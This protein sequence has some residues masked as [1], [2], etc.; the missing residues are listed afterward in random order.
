MKILFIIL[1]I[2]LASVYFYMKQPALINPIVEPQLNSDHYSNGYFNNPIESPVSTSSESFVS[3]LYKFVFAKYE[4]ATPTQSIPSRKTNLHQL[5]PSENIIVWMGHSSYYMQL[6]GKKFLIDPVFSENA[7][8]VPMTNLAFAGSNIYRAEDIPEIDYLLITHDHWDHL[9]YPTLNALRAKIDQIITPIGVGSYLV[10]WGFDANKIYQGDWFTTFE[11]QDVTI[12]VLPA[13]HFSG[14]MLERNQ[15]LW[16]SF[17]IVTAK[18]TIYFSGD[19]GYSPHFKQ[20]AEQIGDID[21]AVLENGQYNDDWAYIHMTPEQAVQAAKDLG[22]KAVL[23][24]HNS[25]F[26]LSRHTW[27]D[28]LQRVY[29]ASLNQPFKLMTPMIGEMVEIDNDQQAFS[30]WWQEIK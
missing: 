3:K 28:P 17:A 14:R 18:H 27:Y 22:T 10:Q 13:Q 12:H 11:Q 7:S 29:N 9:D 8:P 23:P 19:T 21:I 4:E 6:E 15:T 1:A 26:K 25:K 16:A 24:S 5:D 2:A 30:M 20:I